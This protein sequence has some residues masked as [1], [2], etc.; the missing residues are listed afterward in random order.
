MKSVSLYLK[1]YVQAVSKASD[2]KATFSSELTLKM[3]TSLDRK[4]YS[5]KFAF[6]GDNVAAGEITSTTGK[7]VEQSKDY[8]DVIFKA[9]KINNMIALILIIFLIHHVSNEF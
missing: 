8:K 6:S 7:L 5:C 2:D 3:E 9:S 1:R 4:E